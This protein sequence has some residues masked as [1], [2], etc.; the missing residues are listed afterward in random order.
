MFRKKAPSSNDPRKSRPDE[1][2]AEGMPD[3][4]RVVAWVG[5]SMVIKGDLSSSED[6]TIAGDVEGEISVREHSLI[7]GPHATL[8]ANIV[9]RAVTVHGKV[10]GT[11]TASDRVVVGETGDIEGDI[12]APTMAVAEGGMLRGRIGIGAAE[13][14][15]A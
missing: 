2:A 7:V 1:A 5:R 14:S 8:R 9:A 15:S 13:P 3:E 12:T 4:R 10:T 11:I 6:L